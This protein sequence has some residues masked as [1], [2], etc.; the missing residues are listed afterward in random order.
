[1]FFGKDF[2]TLDWGGDIRTLFSFPRWDTCQWGQQVPGE[3]WDAA[4]SWHVGGSGVAEL[5]QVREDGA[6]E[7]GGH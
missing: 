7:N 3:P 4:L 6:R 1:M 5:R 2:S